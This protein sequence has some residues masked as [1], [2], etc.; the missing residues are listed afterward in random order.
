MTV[1][2]LSEWETAI[3]LGA[4]IINWQKKVENLAVRLIWEAE[5]LD[6][7]NDNFV[8]TNQ[9]IALQLRVRERLINGDAVSW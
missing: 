9:D 1:Q 4:A 8:Y 7:T 3:G 6:L 5:S 2:Y